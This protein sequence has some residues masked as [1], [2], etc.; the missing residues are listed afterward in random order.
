VPAVE[1]APAGDVVDAVIADEPFTPPASPPGTPAA[2]PA[3][4][5]QQ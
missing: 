1:A 3:P 2:P 5:A 4:P